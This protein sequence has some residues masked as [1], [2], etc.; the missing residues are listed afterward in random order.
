M[1]E[2]DVMYDTIEALS[3]YERRL[4]RNNVGR[5]WQGKWHRHPGGQVNLAPGTVIIQ[6]ARPIQ[7]GLCDGSS[8]IIGMRSIQITPEM[9][10]QRIAQFVAVEMKTPKG[11]TTEEQDRFI[12]MVEFMGGIAGVAKNV[13]EATKLLGAV[14]K[15]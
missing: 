7:V 14:K 1:S 8:D 6:H 13:D 5:A 9:V 3:K 10:G 2:R 12:A 11:A 15:T 4:F